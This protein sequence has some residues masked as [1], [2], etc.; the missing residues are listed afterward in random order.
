MI[1]VK[2]HRNTKK[3][4]VKV[5]GSECTDF[6]HTQFW[7]LTKTHD[8][9]EAKDGRYLYHQLGIGEVGRD[10][11]GRLRVRSK[12]QM[13]KRSLPKQ[14]QRHFKGMIKRFD[15]VS[16]K[17]GWK[18]QRNP[19]SKSLVVRV[20]KERPDLMAWAYVLEKLQ[21]VFHDYFIE[22]SKISFALY[23]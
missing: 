7:G 19:M 4:V 10:W 20:P 8:F 17:E 6:A 1:S 22:P 16:P 2:L 5:V 14:L 11:R 23:A 9:E 21:P 3:A 13:D 15:Q 12:R 18:K